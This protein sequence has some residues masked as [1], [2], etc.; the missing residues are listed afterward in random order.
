MNRLLLA[1]SALLLSH[2]TAGA[3]VAATSPA[4]QAAPAASSPLPS[5][6][7]AR[8]VPTACPGDIEP[9]FPA[10][11]PDVRLLPDSTLNIMFHGNR[12]VV[13][14]EL[15]DAFQRLNP[16]QRVSYTSV[17]PAFTIQT[18]Q[19]G[20]FTTGNNPVRF[21]PDLVMGNTFMG[22]ALADPETKAQAAPG[23]L[24]SRIHGL[25]LVGRAGDP[26]LAS[27]DVFKILN[28][29]AVRVLLPT[30]QN[31]SH[32]LSFVVF[33]A[34]KGLTPANITDNKR[35]GASQLRHHRSIPARLLAQC[36]DVGFQFLQSQPFLEAKYPGKFQFLPYGIDADT[37]SNEDSYAYV[38][39]N[40]KRRAAAEKFTAFLTS[41]EAVAILRRYR[42]EP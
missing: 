40:S 24:Y 18:L 1:A 27:R 28:D 14:A 20:T 34:I 16:G 41:P 2:I 25:V 3:Q 12:F 8:L 10:D 31:S 7:Q 38:L 42:L 29:P 13:A 5:G 4:A 9:G 23:V 11:D 35:F 22:K 15:V 36:E 26:K 33:A 37:A 21:S 19:T 32:P 30:V 39:T 6:R 17:P